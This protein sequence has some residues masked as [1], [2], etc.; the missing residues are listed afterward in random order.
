M[1]R[2]WSPVSRR[3]TTSIS[4]A[5]PKFDVGIK[6]DPGIV[7]TMV[8]DASGITITGANEAALQVILR[9]ER[10]T[11]RKDRG[12]R[13]AVPLI[14]AVIFG[15]VWQFAAVHS[16]A[17]MFPTAMQTVRAL[18]REIHTSS[19]WS[20]MGSTGEGMAIGFGISFAI[21]IVLGLI[22]AQM[23]K[24]D[25]G[26]N[27]YLGIFLVTP[28]AGIIPLLLIATGLTLTTRVLVVIVFVLPFVAINTRA[29]VR[30]VPREL[31]EMARCFGASR[32]QIW[33]CVILP[34]SIPALATAARLGVARAFEGAIIV[35]LLLVPVGIG[36]R[37]L[38]DEDQFLGPD[39]Y[40]TIL[41]VVLLALGFMAIVRQL[42][43]MLI[44]GFNGRAPS[45]RKR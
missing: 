43:A 40:A 33:R 19:V 23:D 30:A 31:I 17:F 39:L 26:V 13:F 22:M 34:G 45:A 35:E 20:A 10:R 28:M 11:R 18:F 36:G 2:S 7:S 25:R 44:G 27:I 5:S 24:L 3:A 6:G 4:G 21:G 12:L 37:I 15:L 1:S 8:S 14:T 32:R 9:A 38:S 41:F 42:E 29:G 16:H